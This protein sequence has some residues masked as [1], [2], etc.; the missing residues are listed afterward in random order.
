MIS[1]PQTGMN[2]TVST[3]I[4]VRD[5][6]EFVVEAVNSACS[7]TLSPSEVRVRVGRRL[8]LE[9]DVVALAERRPSAPTSSRRT[10]YPHCPRPEVHCGRQGTIADLPA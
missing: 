4:P 2:H 6:R 10:E 1:R 8:V 9:C 3:V 5:R 7:Q